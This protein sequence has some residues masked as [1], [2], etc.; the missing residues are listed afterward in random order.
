MSTTYLLASSSEISE[1]YFGI[2]ELVTV[3]SE[4]FLVVGVFNVQPNNIIWHVMLVKALINSEH[5]GG[6]NAVKY[7]PY[8]LRAPLEKCGSSS[9]IDDKP[10]TTREASLEDQ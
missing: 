2:W 9:D 7:K 3:P 8:L 5:G 6:L 1:H 4:V 10:Q